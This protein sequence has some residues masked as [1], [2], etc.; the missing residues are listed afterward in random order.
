M[1]QLGMAAARSAARLLSGESFPTAV[2]TM[3]MGIGGIT[4]NIAGIIT[5]Q[6]AYL[7]STRP[8]LPFFTFAVVSVGGAL[9]SFLMSE[10]MGQ[11]L[12]TQGTPTTTPHNKEDSKGPDSQVVLVSICKLKEPLS[13]LEPC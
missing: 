12:D 2:R 3:G 11:P 6:L 4:S 1:G 10:T 8:S 5:P 13:D 9:I 7:G